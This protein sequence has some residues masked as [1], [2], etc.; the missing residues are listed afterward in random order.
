MWVELEDVTT[1]KVLLKNVSSLKKSADVNLMLLHPDKKLFSGKIKI[2][3][4]NMLLLAC[5]LKFFK[6]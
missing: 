6:S 3:L 5:L 4:Q 1:G 2:S